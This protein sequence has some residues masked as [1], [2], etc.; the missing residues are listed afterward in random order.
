M[1]IQKKLLID[2]LNIRILKLF[3]LIKISVNIIIN[4]ML[5]IIIKKF[6]MIN[7]FGIFI[8]KFR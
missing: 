2:K 5:L 3:I 6:F 7:M 8:I 1:I 4:I